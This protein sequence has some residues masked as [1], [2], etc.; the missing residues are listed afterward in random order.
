MHEQLLL[1]EEPL[2]IKLGKLKESITKN[3]RSL[4]AK[5]ANA[6]KKINEIMMRLETVEKYLSLH[7]TSQKQTNSCEIYELALF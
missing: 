2:D 6:E 1:F 5:D 7:E 4:H 3:L